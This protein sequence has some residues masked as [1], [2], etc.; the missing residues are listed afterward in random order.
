MSKK[1]NNQIYEAD[2]IS[3]Y[4]D[5][6]ENT[7]KKYPNNVA[8]KYK[9]NFGEENERVIEKKYKEVKEDIE[10]LGTALLGLDLENEKIAIISNNRYE[11]C[12]SYL[13]VTTSNMVAVPLDK[14]LP[15]DD[16]FNLIKRS[17]ATC[18]I[19]EDKY[20]EIF[21]KIKEKNSTN[22]KHYINMDLNKNNLSKDV[23]SEISFEKLLEDGKQKI[24]NG[25]R[26]YFNVK[27]DEDKISILI[28]TSGTTAEAKGVMLSQKNI[29]SNI[30][31]MAKMSR[32]TEKDN[33]LSFLPLHH[34]FECTISF[35]Y[36]FY[37][38][39]TLCFC[40]GLKSIAKNLKEYK[41]TDFVAVP[42][43]LETIYKKIEKE[44]RDSGKEKIVKIM[45]KIS[46][47]LL[48][49][50]IDIRKKVFK[51]VFEA[52]GGNIR[53]V[54]F[55]AASMNKDVIKGFEN[56]G[57]IAV[58][59]YGLTE[60]SPLISAQTDIER[61]PGSVGMAP[62][63][64]DLKLIDLDENGVGEIVV[65]GPNVMLGY[66]EN[67]EATKEAFEDGYFKTGDLG[68]FD[69]DGYLF[70]AGRKKEVIVLKNGENIYPN[71]I[72]N[73]INELPYIEE[74]IV[75]PRENDKN[76]IALGVKVV[77]DDKESVKRFE[78]KSE[79]ERKNIIWEDIKK[80]NQK[81]SQFRRIKELIVTQEPLEKTTTKKIK[82]F[83]EI[84][85]ILKNFIKKS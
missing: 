75:F 59:G 2:E 78:D 17:R 54:H 42:L 16:I 43:I 79:E 57:I 60:T 83:I 68:Y 39:I 63:N 8:Y 19:Y 5:M 74:S 66:Y 30:V 51:S 81:L 36:G 11:W 24:V 38:G 55:G 41:I 77:L 23:Q 47:F 50:R 69:K 49:F 82:R 85:K 56:F 62:Y 70:I 20:K 58:Q 26:S 32:I 64:V 72:E 76:E 3:N 33:L 15:E 46:N 28:F 1:L 4:R 6:I 73:L 7:M 31:A 10:Y 37:S 44:I 61:V 40:D 45:S 13:A 21:M 9:I 29:C 25:D 18:V 80:I 22:L 48:L 27:I 35:L 84:D 34:T 12:V 71:D 65:K 52:L 53:A 14:S 67:E